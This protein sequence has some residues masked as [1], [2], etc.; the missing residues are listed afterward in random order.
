MS[1]CVVGSLYSFW[2]LGNM[3]E[4]DGTRY[5]TYRSLGCRALG[6][7]LGSHSMKVISCGLIQNQIGI[8]LKW[9]LLIGMLIFT[10]FD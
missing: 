3:H 7:S 4:M 10:D 9:T 2:L 5:I 8:S 1:I 6:K